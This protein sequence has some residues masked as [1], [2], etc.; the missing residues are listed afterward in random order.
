MRGLSRSLIRA[1]LVLA[2]GAAA[3][4]I[5]PSQATSEPRDAVT[6]CH[7][8]D[9]GTVV[10]LTLPPV[11]AANHLDH[12]DGLVGDPIPGMAGYQYGPDC[13]PE[14]I[15]NCVDLPA[16]DGTPS[17]N[18]AADGWQ[19]LAGAV[20][21]IA[22]NGPWPGP[23]GTPFVVS[24]VVGTSASGGEMHMLISLGGSNL[25]ESAETELTGLTAG[26]E[27][28]LALEWQ[29][30]TVSS[31]DRALSGGS[32][33]VMVDGVLHSFSSPLSSDAHGWEV[34]TVAFVP[35]ASTASVVV[36]S[37]LAGA[38]GD[39]GDG[40]VVFDAGGVCATL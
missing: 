36:Q 21:I 27:V 13:Q 15:A 11:A 24:D 29:Q 40:M 28:V 10:A 9:E 26:E 17:F 25:V 1:V 39:G 22:G 14:A 3:L 6:V 38:T 4:A 23:V 32:L 2:L 12:G 37:N 30:A 16:V 34:I 18:S 8:T 5:T 31:P 19:A 20:D 33:D 7:A 35:T